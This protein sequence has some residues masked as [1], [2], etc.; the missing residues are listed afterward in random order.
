[1]DIA[2]S[3]ERGFDAFF[4]WLPNLVGALVILLV[5]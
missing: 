3:A 2:N 5:G 1:M 4:A